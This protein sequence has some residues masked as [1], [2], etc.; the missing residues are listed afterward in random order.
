MI[1][2]TSAGKKG[3]LDMQRITQDIASAADIALIERAFP[4]GSEVPHY[5]VPRFW[6]NRKLCNPDT[7]I[8]L[9]LEKPTTEDLARTVVAYGPKRVL[10]NL[11]KLSVEGE[12]T[13]PFVA[14]AHDWLIPV[15]KGIANA[16]RELVAT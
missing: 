12:L 4:P 2:W 13:P 16:A 1:F 3:G 10:S 6:S 14:R 8:A 11:D 9:V 7:I 15:I 5:D